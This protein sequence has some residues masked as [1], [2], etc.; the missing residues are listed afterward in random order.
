MNRLIPFIWPSLLWPG[1][2]HK[3]FLRLCWV[4]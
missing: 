2:E 4:N 3:V 1:K